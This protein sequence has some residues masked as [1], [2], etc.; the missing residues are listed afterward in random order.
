MPIRFLSLTGLPSPGK[1]RLAQ[2]LEA[3]G[4]HI[5]PSSDS[6]RIHAESDLEG[7]VDAGPQRETREAARD[8]DLVIP[9]DWERPQESVRRVQELIASRG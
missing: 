2:A 6:L 3:A 1:A 9:V 5:A 8:A 4:L 7:L